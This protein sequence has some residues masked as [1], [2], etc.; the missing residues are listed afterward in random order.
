[1]PVA[2]VTADADARE[3][4]PD[5]RDGSGRERANAAEPRAGGDDVEDETSM[6][7]SHALMMETMKRAMGHQRMEAT[8]MEA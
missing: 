1:M 6:A 8:T 3:S 2:S 7:S 4:V 5:A